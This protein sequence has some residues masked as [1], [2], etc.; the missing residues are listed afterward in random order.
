MGMQVGGSN[1]GAFVEMN[2]VPLIDILLVLLTIFMI[3]AEQQKGLDAR[4]P[5]PAT[6]PAAETSPGPIVIEVRSG[7]EL[8][9]NQVP[10]AWDQLGR[11]LEEIFKERATKVAFLRGD[12]P[13]EF[14]QV[15]RAL[16]VIHGAG[17]SVALLT[18]G[19]AQSR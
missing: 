8:L 6:A 15:A 1:G 13:L 19:L 16:D 9:I 5:Q 17:I 18:T 4:I 10:V 7:G 14:A 12:A 2:V 3:M 11:R